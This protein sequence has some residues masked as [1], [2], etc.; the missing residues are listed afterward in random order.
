MFIADKT[1]D[2]AYYTFIGVS[3]SHMPR[4]SP[5]ELLSLGVHSY[6]LPRYL[7]V[8]Y[9][10]YWCDRSTPGGCISCDSMCERLL[11]EAGVLYE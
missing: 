9:M 3:F 6:S 10:C 11:F 2:K 7:E 8:Y 4:E 5:E 1:N